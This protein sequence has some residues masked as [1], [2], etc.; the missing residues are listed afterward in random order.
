MYISVS[1]VMPNSDGRTVRP[2]VCLAKTRCDRCSAVAGRIMYGPAVVLMAYSLRWERD[3]LPINMQETAGS[4]PN[5]PLSLNGFSIHWVLTYKNNLEGTIAYNDP[6][7][8]AAINCPISRK[9]DDNNT[10]HETTKQ[11]DTMHVT[12]CKWERYYPFPS[13]AC[14]VGTPMDDMMTTRSS[15]I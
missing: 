6:V 4:S 7:Q 5:C 10:M 2:T 12:N 13:T 14:R 1:N 15:T 3:P 11:D 9:T 8:D